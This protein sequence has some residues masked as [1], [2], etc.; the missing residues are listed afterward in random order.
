ME[1]PTSIENCHRMIRE[2]VEENAVLRKSGNDFGHLAERLNAAL[3]EERRFTE[4][5][6]R[7]SARTSRKPRPNLIEDGG[8]RWSTVAA[9]LQTYAAASGPIQCRETRMPLREV[10][11]RPAKWVI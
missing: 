6:K 3:R 7:N 9:G 5:L 8:G 2:L 1:L 4:Q 11:T 10:R